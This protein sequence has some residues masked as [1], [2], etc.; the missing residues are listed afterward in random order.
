MLRLRHCNRSKIKP[1]STYHRFF[2]SKTH[3]ELYKVADQIVTDTYLTEQ[4]I[5]NLVKTYGEVTGVEQ[6]PGLLDITPMMNWC[7]MNSYDLLR[8]ICVHLKNK[9]LRARGEAATYTDYQFNLVYNIKRLQDEFGFTHYIDTFNGFKMDIQ[10]R[11][12]LNFHELRS[13]STSHQ[14]GEARQLINPRSFDAYHGAGTMHEILM[15]IVYNKLKAQFMGHH[16]IHNEITVKQIHKI[17]NIYIRGYLGFSESH[18]LN[19]AT[20]M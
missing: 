8:R 15:Q 16:S 17:A 7:E 18:L 19:L 2:T 1:K 13:L 4:K 3:I 14:Y 12:P 10:L 9:K 6:S 20:V 11:R 5:V